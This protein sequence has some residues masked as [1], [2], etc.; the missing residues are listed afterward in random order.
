MKRGSRVLPI[1]QLLSITLL[2]CV[3]S[4]C[5]GHSSAPPATARSFVKSVPDVASSNLPPDEEIDA[6][7]TGLVAVGKPAS[8]TRVAV[9]PFKTLG[10]KSDDWV[11]EAASEIVAA[12]LSSLDG[13]SVLERGE[14]TALIEEIKRAD[15]DLDREHIVKMGHLLGAQEMVLGK[16]MTGT[17]DHLT[18]IAHVARVDTGEWV[19][20]VEITVTAG[21]LPSSVA[22]AAT[23]I[24]SAV[25]GREPVSGKPSAPVATPLDPSH[26]EIASRARALQYS[27]KLLEAQPLYA[28]ALASPSTAW[29][30]E[31]DYVRLLMDLGLLAMGGQ[32]GRDVLQRMPVSV[33]TVCDRAKVMLEVAREKYGVD[34]TREAVRTAASCG[35]PS[36]IALA[37][38]H[39]ANAMEDVDFPTSAAALK[40]AQAIIAKTT[41]K[42]AACWIDFHAD[43]RA[44]YEGDWQ[45]DRTARMQSIAQECQDSG[46]L[47][48]GAR[49]LATAGDWAPDPAHRLELYQ[50]ALKVASVVG[51]A[52][53]DETTRDLASNL[54]Q[55]GQAT[56]A[57]Q[58]LLDAL[59]IRIRA[60]EDLS[61]GMPQPLD[62]LDADLLRDAHVDPAFTPSAGAPKEQLLAQAHR[63]AAAGLLRDWAG[64]TRAQ[65][66]RQA[67]FYAAIANELSPDPDAGPANE[68]ADA[69]LDRMLAA[70]KLPLQTIAAAA[71][72][73]LRDSGASLWDAY[74]ALSSWLS[75]DYSREDDK[76]TA[77][78]A[79]AKKVAGWLQRPSTT[80]DELMLE[81]RALEAHALHP[82]ALALARA[83]DR[84]APDCG[85]C[86]NEEL[87]FEQ[88]VLK[89]SD[90]AAMMA[91]S[92]KRAEVAKSISSDAW[93]YALYD[94]A[95]D[96]FDT[97]Q[98]T[99]SYGAR[100]MVTAA[101]TLSDA[102]DFTASGEALLL[103]GKLA[104][105]GANRLGTQD[106]TLMAKKR[107]ELLDQLQDPIASLDARVAVLEAIHDYYADGFPESAAHYLETEPYVASS[108][109]DI[110]ARLDALVKAGQER[111]AARFVARIPFGCPGLPDLAKAALSWSDNFKD[112]VEYPLIAARIWL[113]RSQLET[114]PA[115]KVHALQ[116][117]RDYFAKAQDVPS[118][119]AA[120]K[121]MIA[122][123]T[124]EKDLWAAVDA[125]FEVARPDPTQPDVCVGG[126]A[127]AIYQF[128]AAKISDIDKVKALLDK[129]T[130]L[131][132]EADTATNPKYR[133]DYRA[134]LAKLAALA[135]S[136]D[137]MDKYE[138]EVKA[139]ADKTPSY[140]LAL[141]QMIAG[142][143]EM[144]TPR[145]PKRGLA[146]C[147]EFQDMNVAAPVWKASFY[148]ECEDVARQAGDARAV[149]FFDGEGRKA[150]EIA[151]PNQLPYFDLVLV[152]QAMRVRDWRMA[153]KA[154]LQASQT[155]RKKLPGNH[156]WSD[157][158]DADG[159]MADLFLRDSTRADALLAPLVKDAQHRLSSG[160]TFDRPCLDSDVLALAAASRMAEG[161]CADGEQLRTFSHEVAQQCSA[162]QCYP[163][164][165]GGEWCDF[166]HLLVKEPITNA[167]RQPVP[168]TSDNLA[169]W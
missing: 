21:D 88:A 135:G 120:A 150:A 151:D 136:W 114:D 148:I 111:D 132:S 4:S 164:E 133:I 87:A 61:G 110:Q 42:W 19:K 36:V 162:R 167:C 115:Q 59:G 13:V 28:Q 89:A 139:Y 144:A 26:L 103:A 29:R 152:K 32:H 92:S 65:S 153:A 112:S 1:P 2:G 109:P 143:T 54:R 73:P 12:D 24:A 104:N 147:Q 47:R 43:L 86:K 124:N 138:A 14:L 38:R 121:R 117:A 17:G 129:G 39:Y 41:D 156:Y 74:W 25:T 72:A 146:F 50:Q 84:Y 64:R 91:A 69:R 108:M 169:T 31:A 9:A 96:A 163:T 78:A 34:E 98:Q 82:Q 130:S 155:V 35:D 15:D 118:A 49:A 90:P 52:I 126:A 99:A 128:G 145:D 125:C 149:A 140:R 83:G 127:G 81:A 122:E 3:A 101:K 53:I 16:L 71:D 55:R 18:L 76:H 37:L 75:D 79:A 80:R 23:T 48:I 165:H 57:D 113:Q 46:N 131:V 97:R 58:R 66:Q 93:V 106:A 107:V 166:P 137:V 160:G 142:L 20:A 134:S 70:A 5:G 161:R 7:L 30:F 94:G 168:A 44:A 27:G 68:Q 60:L 33:D 56:A 95:Y 100:V 62:R 11:G 77:V 45:G 22:P 123:A 159:A 119:V 6:L 105:M 158:L 141:G 67:D 51:G 10:A 8:A 85:T 154:Y 40:R 116:T 63:E 102:H 157:E